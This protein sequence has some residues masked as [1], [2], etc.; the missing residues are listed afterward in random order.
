MAEDD[1]WTSPSELAE[2]AYCPRARWYRR[3]PPPGAPDR[4]AAAR[5]R[6]GLRYH[7]RIL[8]AERRRSE[9]G[10]AYWTGLLL[11]LLLVGLGLLWALHLS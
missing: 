2:Y 10:G 8:S 9:H 7:H 1:A 6:A 3:H 4:A 5:R 11:G